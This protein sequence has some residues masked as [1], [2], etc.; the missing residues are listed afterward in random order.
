VPLCA[1]SG[2]LVLNDSRKGGSLVLLPGTTK[3]E[4]GTAVAGNTFVGKPKLPHR[5]LPAPL[6]T[7]DVLNA[8]L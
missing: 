8:E 5:S 2:N 6:N 1:V 7:W 4:N 3:A